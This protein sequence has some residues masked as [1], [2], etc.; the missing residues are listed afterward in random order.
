M[1]NT[2]NIGLK[3]RVT[4]DWSDLTVG[5][6]PLPKSIYSVSVKEG[7]VIES[8]SDIDPVGTFRLFTGQ[9]YYPVSII[10]LARVTNITYIDSNVSI[11]HE[12][13]EDTTNGSWSVNGSKGDT[14]TVTKNGS[15]WSCDCTGFTFRRT[16]KHISIKQKELLE[17]NS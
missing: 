3:I 17:N 7:V 14:Y 11:T 1:I 12:I 10:P 9:S 2:P 8:V 6:M 15:K 4:T 16:C 5:Y 13:K